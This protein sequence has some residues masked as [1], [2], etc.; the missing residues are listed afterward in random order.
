MGQKQYWRGQWWVLMILL[1]FTSPS[2]Y[3]FSILRDTEIETTIHQ[4][5]LPLLKEAGYSPQQVTFIL[6]NSSAINAFVMGGMNIFFASGI[7]LEFEEPEV[8]LGVIAHE[9]GH[10]LGGHLARHSDM[11]KQALLQ[12]TVSYVLGAAAAVGGSPEAALALMHGGTHAAERQALEYSRENE[13]AADQAALRLLSKTH[14]SAK[15]LLK[16][17][18]W[19]KRRESGIM[20]LIDP[21]ARTHPL[22]QERIIHIANYVEQPKEEASSL[23]IPTPL[24]VAYER[25]RAKLQGF[26]QPPEQVLKRYPAKDDSVA[27]RYARAIAYY[28]LP[29]FHHAME[30]IDSLLKDFPKDPYFLELKGQMLFETGQAQASIPYLKKALEILPKSSLFHG[31]IGMA[32][33][34]TTE[35]KTASTFPASVALEQAIY[36]LKQ[37]MRLDP[38]NTQNL[39]QLMIAYG[40]LGQFGMVSL[41]QA[42]K[43]AMQQKWEEASRY[44]E[45]ALKQLPV[46]SPAALKGKDLQ[47]TIKEQKK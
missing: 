5:S 9:L 24:R 23:A 46:N 14:I 10:I 19:L 25:C 29:N 12:T 39:D 11:M 43:A 18:E 1:M 45:Q 15:G 22:S 6:V 35:A 36:H 47:L 41:T 33:I 16:L 13:Q 30:T 20:D 27:A 8:I 42:E 40:K 2:T 44:V 4:M 26:L 34:S 32:Y 3:G 7:L 17:L 31:M 37:A 21:Y 28:R 38:H